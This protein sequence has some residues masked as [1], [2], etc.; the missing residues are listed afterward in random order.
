MSKYLIIGATGRSGVAIINSLL[1]VNENK[2]TIVVRNVT[3]AREILGVECNTSLEVA[4]DEIIPWIEK[5][6][7]IGGI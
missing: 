7:E 1:K 6:I 5:Q 2:I 4:L 3:K